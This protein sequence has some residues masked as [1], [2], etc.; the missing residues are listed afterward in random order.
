MNFFPHLGVS[1]WSKIKKRLNKSGDTRSKFIN[2]FILRMPSC[3]WSTAKILS[4][5]KRT[6][7]K[8]LIPKLNTKKN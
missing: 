3:V 4:Q 7:I 1:V 8:I 6:S 5:S 2:N